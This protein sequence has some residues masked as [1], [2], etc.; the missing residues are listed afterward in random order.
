MAGHAHVFP[1]TPWRGTISDGA[2]ATVRLRSV[3]CA[4]TVEVVF[5]HHALKTFALRSAGNIDKIARLKLRNGQIDFAFWRICFEAELTHEF[6]R[7]R[8]G[9]FE[10]AEQLFRDTRFLLHVEPDLHG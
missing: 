7:F 9:L 3:R 8:A 1:N 2:V 6:L 10:F 5:L 4:L